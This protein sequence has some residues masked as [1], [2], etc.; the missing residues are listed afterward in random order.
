MKGVISQKLM[1]ILND[2]ELRVKFFAE[3]F[4][5]KFI[6]PPN[7]NQL[8]FPYTLGSGATVNITVKQN[9]L[10]ALNIN[11]ARTDAQRGTGYKYGDVLKIATGDGGGAISDETRH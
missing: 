7:P 1:K 5:V 11:G 8:V 3:K 4:G 6:N 2:P 9:G 10:Q